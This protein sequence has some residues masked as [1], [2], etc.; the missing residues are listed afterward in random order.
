MK[1][2]MSSKKH[3]LENLLFIQI[4]SA[5]TTAK[6]KNH[7]ARRN[8]IFSNIYHELLIKLFTNTS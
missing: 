2:N 3:S 8:I 1:A 4:Y 7:S 6:N 5:I